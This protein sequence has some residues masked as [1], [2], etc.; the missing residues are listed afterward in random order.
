MIFFSFI[1]CF[2]CLRFSSAALLMI[3]SA[4]IAL[5]GGHFT[6]ITRENGL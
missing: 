3:F 4:Y 6:S 5:D 1:T 2:F